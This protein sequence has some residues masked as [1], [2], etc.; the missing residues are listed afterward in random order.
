MCGSCYAFATADA[1]AIIKALYSDLPYYIALSAQEIVSSYYEKTYGCKGGAFFSSFDY[2]I[3]TGL[4]Y[5]WSYPYRNEASS[6]ANAP[7]VLR[8]GLWKVR[9]F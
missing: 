8:A 7:L 6:I 3:K 5:A 9:E 2:M 4:Y 1:A